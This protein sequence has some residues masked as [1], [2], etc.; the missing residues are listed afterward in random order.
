MA[1]KPQKGS[2]KSKILT[3]LF[4]AA[5]GNN[6]SKLRNEELTFTYSDPRANSVVNN[7]SLIIIN[8]V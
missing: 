8:D 3:E 1:N 6:S 4:I 5:S 2:G 7:Y